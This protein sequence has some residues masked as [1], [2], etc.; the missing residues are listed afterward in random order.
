MGRGSGGAGRSRAGSGGGLNQSQQ[1]SNLFTQ[2]QSRNG[3]ITVTGKDGIRYQVSAWQGG[4]QQRIYFS[5]EAQSTRGGFEQF[6]NF[7]LNTG[8]LSTRAL[9]GKMSSSQ[10][11][12]TA[13]A[14]LRL[15]NR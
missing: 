6:G 12:N 1:A 11:E 4:N 9:A 15:G 5:R 14:L 10:A 2:A 8:T 7:N 3:R 13:T